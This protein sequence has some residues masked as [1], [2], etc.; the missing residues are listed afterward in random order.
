VRRTTDQSVRAELEALRA[1]RPRSASCG[2]SYRADDE[3]DDGLARVLGRSWTRPR[4]ARAAPSGRSLRAGGEE[5]GVRSQAGPR[6]STPPSS[7]SV[8]PVTQL[9]PS[10]SR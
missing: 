1:E 4:R 2:G 3:T 6:D 7:T 5:D 10:P 9:A 8:W